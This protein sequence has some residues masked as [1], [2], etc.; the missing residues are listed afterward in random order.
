MRIVFVLPAAPARR[1]GVLRMSRARQAMRQV[2]LR[3]LLP[4]AL[5]ASMASFWLAYATG[6]N[7][8]AAVT[9]P[10][11]ATL[12]VGMLAERR[13]PYRAAWSR[14]RQ[15]VGTDLASTMVLLAMVDP[16]LKWLGP[17]AATALLGD[18]AYAG[19]PAI[20]PAH[21]PFAL[22]VLLA[23]LLAEFGSYWAHRL[24]HQVP[25]LWWLHAL[26]HG[27]ERLYTLNNFRFHPL[28]Y[29]LNYAMGILPL[30]LLGVP[31]AVILGYFA[32]T[33]PVLM[34]QHANL[35]LQNGWLNHVFSTNDVHRWHHS[36]RA[37]E[38]DTN[39]GRSLVIWDQV[40]GTYRNLPARNDPAEVGLYHGSPYPARS[41][42]LAQVGS[43]F[44]A[45][46][47]R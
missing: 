1:R 2:F 38:G 45:G 27:S 32:V 47:C 40:F 3:A 36:A 5:L 44:T 7:L 35:P 37:G 33:L 41:S 28:N 26:H 9:L 17:V 30:L 22:Q 8:E 29:V 13:M 16:L 24:H 19:A 20:F 12:A 10:A 4:V 25:A 42:F 23:T 18:S 6:G 39:F 15:D 11:I 43:M 21:W 31:Q 34:L 46:C 14:S